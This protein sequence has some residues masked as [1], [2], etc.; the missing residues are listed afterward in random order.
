MSNKSLLKKIVS[1]HDNNFNLLTKLIPDLIDKIESSHK[2][3]N[4]NGIE[5]QVNIIRVN[6]IESIISISNTYLQNGDIMVDLEFIVKIFPI[7]KIIEVISYQDQFGI[8][9]AYTSDELVLTENKISLNNY[10]NKWLKS[11]LKNNH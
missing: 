4:L 8:V 10:L 3:I 2:K 6:K 11:K 5:F 1:I 7:Q 9:E